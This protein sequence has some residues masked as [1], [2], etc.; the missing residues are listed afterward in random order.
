GKDLYDTWFAIISTSDLALLSASGTEEEIVEAQ[1]LLETATGFIV[2]PIALFTF[3]FLGL[4]AT[5]TKIGDVYVAQRTLDYLHEMQA[6]R[7][8]AETGTMG[9]IDGR[10]FIQEVTPDQLEKK[11]A[12]LNSATAWGEREAKP[13]GLKEP[14]TKDNKKW[15]KILGPANVAT[16]VT[17]K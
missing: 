17:A 3:C 1:R 5:L 6:K 14:L 4:S 10:F 15:L 2:E 11:N 8:V 9:M 12:A 7:C 13:V 16:I